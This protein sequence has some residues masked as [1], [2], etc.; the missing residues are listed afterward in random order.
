MNDGKILITDDEEVFLISTA[1]ILRK[2]GFECDCAKNGNEALEK[3]KKSDYDLLIADIK[4]PGNS[5][6]E[7]VKEINELKKNI[8]TLLV[9]GY[10]ST[11]SAVQAVGLPVAGYLLKPLDIQ[12]LLEKTGNAIQRSKLNK[13]VSKTKDRLDYML[14]ELNN[15]EESMAP[16]ASGNMPTTLESFM[17][18]SCSNMT[19]TINDIKNV[20]LTV[21]VKNKKEKVCNL[22][23]CPRLNELTGALEDTVKVL[24]KTKNSFK[25]KELGNLRK[26]LENILQKN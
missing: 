10:P 20:L 6:L 7:L 9:T 26:K 8:P 11:D 21:T 23:N 16:D 22:M 18:I 4:M 25:S 3:I 14:K 15:I 24:E 12:E 1:D 13:M 19:G 2:E 17:D 5:D